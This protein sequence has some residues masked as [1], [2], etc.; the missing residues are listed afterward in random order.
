VDQVAATVKRNNP[1]FTKIVVHYNPQSGSSI[2]NHLVNKPEIVY[3]WFA[4]NG[5]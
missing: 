1:I 5:A 2:A 3:E 4:S